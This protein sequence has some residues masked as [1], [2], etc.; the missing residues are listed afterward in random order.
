MENEGS[1]YCSQKPTTKFYVEQ[2]NATNIPTWYSHTLVYALL[3]KA[4]TRYKVFRPNLFPFFISQCSYLNKSSYI[5]ETK[6][7]TKK[8]LV[9]YRQFTE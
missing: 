8:G 6:T 9:R 3:S 5:G 1:S 2:L 4:V 7:T